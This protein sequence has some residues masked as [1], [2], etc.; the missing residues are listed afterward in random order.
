[1]PSEDELRRMRD[2]NQSNVNA[3]RKW[4]EREVTY[5]SINDSIYLLKATRRRLAE[6]EGINEHH[7]TS[8]EVGMW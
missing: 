5:D 2:L 1:M 8:P 6:L 7:I 3:V 4:L